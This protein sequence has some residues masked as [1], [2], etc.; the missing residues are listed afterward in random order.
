M[1][2]LAR[3]C[4]YH[5]IKRVKLIASFVF[6][7]MGTELVQQRSKGS[8]HLQSFLGNIWEKM[9]LGPIKVQRSLMSGS[10]CRMPSF[11]V[12]ECRQYNTSRDGNGLWTLSIVISV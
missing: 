2:V 5:Y 11:R 3:K 6:Q 1:D 7:A 10:L 8:S 12:Y 9:N 4:S